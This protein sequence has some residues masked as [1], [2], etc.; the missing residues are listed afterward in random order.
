LEILKKHAA[1][2][3][4]VSGNLPPKKSFEE[5]LKELGVDPLKGLTSEEVKNRQ[6]KFGHNEV[7]E[8][9]E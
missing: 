9:K 3:G 1:Q 2:E 8:K 7:V 4:C 6:K 5:L